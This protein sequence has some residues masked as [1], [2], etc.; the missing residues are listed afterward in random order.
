LGGVGKDL[1]FCLP[2]SFFG[3]HIPEVCN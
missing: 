3:V 2:G 1:A